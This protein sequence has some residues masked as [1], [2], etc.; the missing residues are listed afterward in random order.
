[1]STSFVARNIFEKVRK[2]FPAYI[3][4][5][6]SG[7][8]RNPVNQ[9]GPEELKMIQYFNDY[10]QNQIWTGDIE[11]GGIKYLAKFSAMRMEKVCLRCHGNPADAPI[12]LIKKYDQL[13]KKI[14]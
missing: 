10:P 11:M 1:M 6:S 8:P 7:N 9:A 2:N 3:I 13:I 4:K 12:E 14:I 5:F